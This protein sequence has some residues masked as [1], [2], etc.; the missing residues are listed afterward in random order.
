[1]R[2]AHRLRPFAGRFSSVRD[3]AVIGPL[4]VRYRAVIGPLSVRYRAVIGSLS[5]RYRPVIGPLSAPVTRTVSRARTHT[6]TARAHAH[7]FLFSQGCNGRH[8][9]NCNIRRRPGA[10]APCPISSLLC[11]DQIIMAIPYPCMIRMMLMAIPVSSLRAGRAGPRPDSVV[12][13]V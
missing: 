2:L 13:T 12:I 5:V 7:T 1:M 9:H 4:S 11:D 3:R 6:D 10:R 8:N